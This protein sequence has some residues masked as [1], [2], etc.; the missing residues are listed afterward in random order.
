[1]GMKAERKLHRQTQTG[2]GS[3]RGHQACRV[4]VQVRHTELGAVAV[5][6]T[7]QRLLLA[8][9]KSTFQSRRPTVLPS[10]AVAGGEHGSVLRSAGLG[11]VRKL[12]LLV[13]GLSAE[14][15][16]VCMKVQGSERM[17]G[18]MCQPEGPGSMLVSAA[19]TSWVG[20]LLDG[21][22]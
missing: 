11:E 8:R 7:L 5:A 2:G 17:H 21:E 4:S 19:V 18:D 20:G 1:M 3:S 15:S 6:P 22:R 16:V 14:Y 13:L 9:Q 10:Q 12:A